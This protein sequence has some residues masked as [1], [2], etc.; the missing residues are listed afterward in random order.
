MSLSVQPFGSPRYTIAVRVGRLLTFLTTYRPYIVAVAYIAAIFWLQPSS[1]LGN[2]G[3]L[4][5][6]SQ[7]ILYDDGDW[8]AIGL[9]ALNAD[10]GKKPGRSVDPCL[11]PPKPGTRARDAGP[12]VNDSTYF[13]EYPYLVVQL[14]KMPLSFGLFSNH[15]R[16]SSDVLGACHWDFV[17][18]RPLSEED[19]DIRRE[20]R[21]LIR[22]YQIGMF[23]CLVF[24]IAVLRAGYNQSL[25]V[26]TDIL[27]CLPAFLYFSLNRFDVIP[28]ALTGLSLFLLA[29][30][31]IALSG[32]TLGLGAMV[33]V[34]PVLLVP[35]FVRFLLRQ[36]SQ[37][38]KWLLSFAGIVVVVLTWSMWRVGWS[39]TLLPFR[40]QLSRGLE[41]RSI[42]GLILPASLGTQSWGWLRV[43]IVLL[44]AALLVY[45]PVTNPISLLRRAA[46]VLIVFISLQVFF[47]PQWIVWLAPLLFPLA[48]RNKTLLRW[49][50]L[51]DV[52]MYI[53]FPV[54]Y[55]QVGLAGRGHLLD[56]GLTYIRFGMEMALVYLLVREEWKDRTHPESPHFPVIA[57]AFEQV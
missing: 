48:S 16:Y 33:K 18:Q 19:R 9:R 22:I 45:R 57:P 21:N 50:I 5:Y 55:D 51:L 24:L 29:R 11:L 53:S 7:R 34:Y 32:A 35:L 10:A 4:G 40:Y 43:A 44:V 39:G 52:A 42:Y 54:V 1:D 17:W 38:V 25:R 49:V 47:S 6:S 15:L 8:A 3:R 23:A 30:R 26:T 12:L 36:E 28:S 31:R 27:F 2:S 37:V 46:V 20:L 13:L 56:M 14:F 41:P